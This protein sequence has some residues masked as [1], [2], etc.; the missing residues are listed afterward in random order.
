MKDPEAEEDVVLA[1][2]AILQRKSS[3]LVDK[4][5]RNRLDGCGFNLRVVGIL[6]FLILWLP[7]LKIANVLIYDR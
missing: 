5:V 6:P 4:L 2:L 7:R 3:Q 1:A